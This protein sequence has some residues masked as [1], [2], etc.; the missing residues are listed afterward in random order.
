MIG[1]PGA[2]HVAV[3]DGGEV[4]EEVLAALVGGDEAEPAGVPAARHAGLALASRGRRRP[5]SAPRG[6]AGSAAGP[7]AGRSAPAAVAAVVGGTRAAAARGGRRRARRRRRRGARRCRGGCPGGSPW[8]CSR[9]CQGS[10]WGIEHTWRPRSGGGADGLLS[11]LFFVST[12]RPVFF[13]SHRLSKRPDDTA[14]NCP[15]SDRHKQRRNSNCLRLLGAHRW[16]SR[17]ARFGGRTPRCG[18]AASPRAR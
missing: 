10:A 6:R 1:A 5:V 9:G 18:S 12:D 7:A 15:T 16:A 4:A 8:W 3:G 17:A 11:F 14:I 2:H 13:P